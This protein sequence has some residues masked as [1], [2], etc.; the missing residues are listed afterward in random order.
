M[1]ALG[2]GVAL[3][4]MA[5]ATAASALET[6]AAG[7]AAKPAPRTLAASRVVRN[8]RLSVRRTDFPVTHLGLTWPSG[9]AHVRVRTSAGWTTWRNLDGCGGAPDGPGQP[10]MSALVVVPAAVA[11]EVAVAG[12]RTA[13]VTEL[14]T[15]DGPALP[16]SA[17][18]AAPLPPW[19]TLAD[20]WL[21][22]LSR[23]AWG[24]DE[25]LRF[26]NEVET[27]PAE[28]FPPQALTVHHQGDAS[29]NDDPNPAATVRAIYFY[30]AITQDWGDI[31][32]HLLIDEAGR[33]YEGRWSGAPGRPVFAEGKRLLVTTGAHAQGYNTGNVGV[34]LL[35]RFTNTQPTPAARGALVKAL[36]W[37]AHTCELDPLGTTHYVNPV[38]GMTAD[39]NVISGHRNWGA[40]ECPGDAFYPQ[41]P[42][43][44]TD[45]SRVRRLTGRWRPPIP[46]PPSG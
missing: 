41:L 19:A 1:F 24:A 7:P 33:V 20:Y 31:G 16:S 35:G 2:A 32:Y 8:G 30:Q 12:G 42:G 14:N 22:Y 25:S 9:S 34:C 45:V 27:W 40:T 18:V 39:V 44:R 46:R 11:Y 29:G 4:S 43:V 3:G 17:I 38:N 21:S 6:N 23:A 10:A 13:Q 5:S 15:V 26:R 28:Y 36:A 37:L